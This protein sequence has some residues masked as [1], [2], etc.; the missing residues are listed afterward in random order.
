MNKFTGRAV[1]KGGRSHS[2]YLKKLKR[3][4]EDKALLISRGLIT[5]HE[6]AKPKLISKKQAMKRLHAVLDSMSDEDTTQS[7]D[8]KLEQMFEGLGFA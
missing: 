8:L 5:P 6:V 1:K 2:Q 3:E 7:L 4:E